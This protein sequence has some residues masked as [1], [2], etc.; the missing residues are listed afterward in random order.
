MWIFTNN[1]MM[2][3][4]QDRDNP[5][6]FV[7]RSRFRGDLEKAFPNHPVFESLKTDY[8]FRVFVPKLEV[9]MLLIQDLGGVTYDN[10]KNSIPKE[11]Y[12]RY[13]AY[14]DVWAALLMHQE[15]NPFL[16][17]LEQYEEDYGDIDAELQELYS[18]TD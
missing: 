4:V 16:Y 12:T 1:K 9:Y 13:K 5:E 11:D 3:I 2:S 14:E 7:V 6:R 18:R 10:F 17:A 8:Q 15:N